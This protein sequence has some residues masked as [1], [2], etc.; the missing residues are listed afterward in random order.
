M[1][2]KIMT[3]PRSVG[4]ASGSKLFD[5][6]LQQGVSIGKRDGA[7]TDRAPIESRCVR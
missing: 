5:G 6:S 7:H 1:T 3:L 4:D 2:I